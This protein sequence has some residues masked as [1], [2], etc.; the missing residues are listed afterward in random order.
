MLLVD[1]TVWVDYFNGL[2]TPHTDYLDALLDQ[3]LILVGDLI[4]AEVLQGFREDADFDTARRA[5]AKFQQ[6]QMVTPALALQSARNHRLP[7]RRGVT[8]RK[9]IDSLIATW[10]IENGVPLLHNDRDFDAYEA[11]LGLRVLQ[12]PQ[13]I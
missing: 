7:R 9:T 8:V 12:P 11:H 10:C 1:S 6:V 2:R 4:L 3:D 5:L 13:R